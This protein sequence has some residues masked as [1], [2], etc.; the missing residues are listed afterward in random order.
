[1]TTFGLIH[2]A[3]HGAW[4]WGPLEAELRE[5]GHEAVAMDLPCDDPAAGA[6]RYAEVVAEALGD[7]G[8]VVIVGHS[9]FLSRPAALAEMLDHIVRA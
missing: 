9:P 1:M 5:L 4:C 6:A 8:P 2:G 3:F 7:R